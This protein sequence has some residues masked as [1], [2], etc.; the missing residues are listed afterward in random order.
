MAKPNKGNRKRADM[1]QITEITRRDLIDLLIN[2]FNFIILPS[3]KREFYDTRT[4]YYHG[5]LS[6]IDFLKRLYPLNELPSSD[7]R[8]SNAEGDIIQHTVSNDDWD[9]DWVFHDD[10]LKL[11]DGNYDKYLLDFISEIFHPTVRE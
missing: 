6:E 11:S 9:I 2:E 1:K 3:D 5:V 10:R 4:F 7:R 8:Y